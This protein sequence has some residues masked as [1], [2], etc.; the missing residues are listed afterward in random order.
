MVN[1]TIVEIATTIGISPT[2]LT[3]GLTMVLGSLLALAGE[4]LAIARKE[5]KAPSPK[6]ARDRAYDLLAAS[7]VPVSVLAGFGTQVLGIVG[8]AAALYLGRKYVWP[9]VATNDGQ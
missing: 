6:R 2:V 8:G 1:Q 9:R 7:V 3:A 5:F 4:R